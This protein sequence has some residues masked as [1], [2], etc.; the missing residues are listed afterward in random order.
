MKQMIWMKKIVLC[1]LSASVIGLGV[2]FLIR[3]ALGSDPLSVFLDG[4]ACVTKLPL[5]TASLTFNFVM[6]VLA[7]VFAR[8][9]LQVGTLIHWLGLSASLGIFE[10]MVLRLL[11]AAPSRLVRSVAMLAGIV[12]TCAGIALNIAVRLGLNSSDA[13]LFAIKEH[14]HI[15]FVYIRIASDA[16]YTLLGFLLGGVVGVGTVLGIFCMGPLITWFSK[17]YNATLFL[18]LGLA[19]TSIDE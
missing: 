17:R 16:L 10:P 18:W 13:L 8:K 15:P 5:G 19:Q 12:I 2:S 4:F 6:L 1:V 3:A 7:F 9:H 14:F 11:G